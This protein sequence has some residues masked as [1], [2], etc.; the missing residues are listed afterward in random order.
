ML[1]KLFF[2]V[3]FA[4]YGGLAAKQDYYEGGV[5]RWILLLLILCGLGSAAHFL[6]E[7]GNFEA[8]GVSFILTVLCLK[9]FNFKKIWGRADD[10]L[11]VAWSLGYPHLIFGII[12]VAL[13][14]LIF[15]LILTGLN[16][17]KSLGKK[18]GKIYLIPYLLGGWLCA[19]VVFYF[20]GFS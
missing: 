6:V 2:F 17:Y 9:L 18:E 16:N 20:G 7:G 10:V 1:F 8:V 11:V 4:F 15:G 3:W 14:A 13:L 19:L 12:P 5:E